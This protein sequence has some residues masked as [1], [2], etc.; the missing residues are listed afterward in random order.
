MKLVLVENENPS[1]G[2]FEA[3]PFSLLA[4]PQRPGELCES[5]VLELPSPA[6]ARAERYAR[7]ARLPLAL[8]LAIAIEAER[9][10]AAA[11]AATGVDAEDLARA[12]DDAA[13]AV[14]RYDIG[15]LETRRLASYA[16]A[17]RAG[18]AGGWATPVKSG[19]ALRLPH[20]LLARWTF[21]AADLDMS[22]GKWAAGLSLEP[23]RERWEAAAAETA[24]PLSEWLLTQAARLARSNRAT[25]QPAA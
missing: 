11:V 3:P 2:P 6:F 16:A 15:P 19:A 10:L 5:L 1:E 22:L 24:Q 17:L 18:M 14:R 13:R 9:A 21:T 4:Q 25:P 20:L 23:G 8:W 7:A 12:A